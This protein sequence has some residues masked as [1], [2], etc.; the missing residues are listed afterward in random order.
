MGSYLSL[1]HTTNLFGIMYLMLCRSCSLWQNEMQNM[2]ALVYFIAI[3]WVAFIWREEIVTSEHSSNMKAMK[4]IFGGM[5]WYYNYMSRSQ[6][7]LS[8]PSQSKWYTHKPIGRWVIMFFDKWHVCSNVIMP[9]PN[10][11]RGDAHFW[12]MK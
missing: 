5:I 4:L 2:H 10:S 11:L 12:S 8:S 3:V 7:S 9:S 6:I 1:S